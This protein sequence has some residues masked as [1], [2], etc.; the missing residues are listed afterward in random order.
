MIPLVTFAILIAVFISLG[1]FVYR[2]L[3]FFS[4]GWLRLLLSILIALI[5]GLI[6]YFK[7]RKN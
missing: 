2:M 7:R 5:P 1:V 3:W 4:L 6:V